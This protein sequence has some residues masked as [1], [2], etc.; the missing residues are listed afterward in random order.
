MDT[1]QNVNSQREELQLQRDSISGM[2]EGIQSHV[3]QVHMELREALKEQAKRGSQDIAK[4]VKDLGSKLHQIESNVSAE[5]RLEIERLR[6]EFNLDRI[7]NDVRACDSTSPCTPTATCGGDCFKD[8]FNKLHM[9]LHDERVRREADS[10]KIHLRLDALEWLWSTI[11]SYSTSN[12]C[13]PNVESI[14][15]SPSN[16]ILLGNIVPPES[17]TSTAT[18]IKELEEL[19]QACTNSACETKP[20]V[21]SSSAE[22]T[23]RKELLDDA[24]LFVSHKAENPSGHGSF[25]L[26]TNL[27]DDL[28][29]QNFKTFSVHDGSPVSTHAEPIRRPASSERCDSWFSMKRR[30]VRAAT[31]P[32]RHFSPTIQSASMVPGICFSP[33]HDA[34]EFSKPSSSSVLSL[35]EAPLQSLSARHAPKVST[36]P[37]VQKPGASSLSGAPG[38]LIQEANLSRVVSGSSITGLNVGHRPVNVNMAVNSQSGSLRKIDSPAFMMSPAPSGPVGPSRRCRSPAALNRVR[39]DRGLLLNK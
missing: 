31:G 32:R 16:Q 5:I 12:G 15:L 20:C 11:E 19:S 25:N 36:V 7:V 4:V 30:D 29:S 10:V 33:A 28:A 13:Q 17:V 6:N 23:E 9:I 27:S 18:A 34:T 24:Q 38:H 3:S 1:C 39:P 37:T 26:Q 35:R 14:T 21:P 22:A 8:Q 2:L